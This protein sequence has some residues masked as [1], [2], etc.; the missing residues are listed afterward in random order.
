M[1]KIVLLLLGL[2][3]HY[4]LQAWGVGEYLHEVDDSIV[5]W[6]KDPK[7]L[8]KKQIFEMVADYLETLQDFIEKIDLR[9]K[10][11][12]EPG[13]TLLK[14]TQPRYLEEPFKE[15]ILKS[16]FNWRQIDIDDF[17]RLL[18]ETELLWQDFEKSYGDLQKYLQN[19]QESVSS[20]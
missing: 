4:S 5:R 9:R 6:L 20:E 10:T 18:K 15:D 7:T 12:I 11:A 16:E 8:S 14:R 3:T 19:E 2:F 1:L 17:K 13:Q